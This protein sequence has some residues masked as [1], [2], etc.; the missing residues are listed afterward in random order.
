MSTSIDTLL[1]YERYIPV[2]TDKEQ[3]ELLSSRPSVAKVTEWRKRQD[4]QSSRIGEI[5][6][7]AYQRQKENGKF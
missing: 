2:M 6:S 1:R 4:K 3:K 5:F 7:M